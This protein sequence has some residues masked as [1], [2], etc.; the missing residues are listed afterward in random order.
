MS[1]DDEILLNCIAVI[2]SE[3][4]NDRVGKLPIHNLETKE[5][6]KVWGKYYH[7]LNVDINSQ[8]KVT[9]YTPLTRLFATCISRLS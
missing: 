9:V 5:Q 2:S 8:Y 6:V 7:I 3:M 1:L 4:A